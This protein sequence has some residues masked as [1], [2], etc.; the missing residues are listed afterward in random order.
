[1]Y[2][3]S[4]IL[5]VKKKINN[6]LCKN[7]SYQSLPFSDLYIL[8]NQLDRLD[9]EHIQ[10]INKHFHPGLIRSVS[11]AYINEKYIVWEGQHT[12]IVC[13]MNGIDPI[14]CIIYTCEDLE[15]TKLDTIEKLDTK[16]LQHIISTL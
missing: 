11:V 1:M 3:L 10:D 12:A 2:K 8:D 16:Q 15:F 5:E 7:L 6:D 4:E 9:L 14:P 13:Y